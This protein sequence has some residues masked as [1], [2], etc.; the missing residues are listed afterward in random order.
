MSARQTLFYLVYFVV[1][2]VVFSIICFPGEKAANKINAQLA[3]R[4]PNATLHMDKVIPFFPG[5]VH[6]INPQIKVQNRFLI[7]FETLK[8]EYPFFDLF[9]T[10]KTLTFDGTLFSGVVNGSLTNVSWRRKTFSAFDLTLDHLKS[11]NILYTSPHIKADISFTLDGNYSVQANPPTSEGKLTLTDIKTLIQNPFFNG[12]GIQELEF[13]RMDIDFQLE[14][15]KITIL[16]CEAKGVLM[17]ICLKGT[18]IAPKEPLSPQINWV[19]DLKGF[20][21]PQPAYLSKSA[22]LSSMASLFDQ[23]QKQGIPIHISGPLNAPAIEL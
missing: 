1:V 18:L 9:K 19:L 3:G 12:V 21:Q 6:C 7:P 22:R 13:T 20:I 23:T 8:F 10:D 4:F 16:N 11:K 15:K 14:G 17:V 2:C 5:G